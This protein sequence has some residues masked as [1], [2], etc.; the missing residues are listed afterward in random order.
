MQ[1]LG[2]K[3]W[4]STPNTVLNKVVDMFHGSS[5]ANTQDRI[6]ERYREEDSSLRCIVATVAFG[7]GIQ[8]KNIRYIIN[9]GPPADILTYWQEVGRCGR[10]EQPA[11]A[12]LYIFP[13]SLHEKFVDKAMIALCRSTIARNCCIRKA[14]LE[15]LFV[16]GMSRDQ[17][18]NL[19][20]NHC[21]CVCDFQNALKNMT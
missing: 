10:D 7:M 15:S 21:C 18:N 20:H 3:A 14:I 2:A 1:Y 5:H 17:L 19:S 4:S 9:W 6:V 12:F 13:Y 16:E 11:Q 8:V